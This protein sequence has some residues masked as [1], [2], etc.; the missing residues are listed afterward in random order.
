MLATEC[1]SWNIYE[2]G[3]CDNNHQEKMAGELTPNSTGN[4]YLRIEVHNKILL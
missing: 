4:Y 2:Q 3:K 1:E